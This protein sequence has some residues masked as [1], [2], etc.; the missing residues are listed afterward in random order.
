MNFWTAFPIGW[1]ICS[2]IVV[3][4]II[5]KK[6]IFSATV[7]VLSAKI[8]TYGDLLWTAT[9]VALG[10]II[11]VGLGAATVDRLMSKPLPWKKKNANF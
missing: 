7:N 1:L 5:R 9:V 11:L 10:P 4:L 3:L 8:D 2:I 6:R